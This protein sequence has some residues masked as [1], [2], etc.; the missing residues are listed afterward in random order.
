MCESDDSNYA[1]WPTAREGKSLLILAL[2]LLAAAST[3]SL[4]DN[5]NT[6]IA[7]H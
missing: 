5:F 4:P 3:V 7:A 6:T 1:I 2:L